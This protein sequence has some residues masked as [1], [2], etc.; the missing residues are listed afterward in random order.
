MKKLLYLTFVIGNLMYTSQVQA[1]TS[2]LSDV[3]YEEEYHWRATDTNQKKQAIGM[4][5][6]G[7]FLFIA[8]GLISAFIPTCAG[9]TQPFTDPVPGNTLLD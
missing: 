7:V 9:D 3:A 4:V 2:F 5:I 1:N 6:S 8:I